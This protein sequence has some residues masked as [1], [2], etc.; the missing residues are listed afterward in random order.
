LARPL[1][2]AFINREL[3]HIKNKKRDEAEHIRLI[4]N[5]CLLT[6]GSLVAPYA[7]IA[8]LY[9]RKKGVNALVEALCHGDKLHLRSGSSDIYNFI[10]SR[11]ELYSLHRNSYQMYFRDGVNFTLPYRYSSQLRT[12]G[13]IKEEITK[14][15]T[16]SGR[17]SNFISQEDAA[18]LSLNKQYIINELL[19]NDK[20][21]TYSVYR[22]SSI[23]PK[24]SEVKLFGEIST[25][26]FVSHY[27]NEHELIVPTGI[28]EDPLIETF[29]YYPI[30]DVRFNHILLK[31]LGIESII[32][33]TQF[34]QP[35]FNLINDPDFAHY[36]S[37]R[38]SFFNVLAS[39]AK[40]AIGRPSCFYSMASALSD[41]DF[42]SAIQ[43]PQSAGSLAERLN[44]SMK[45]TA[46]RN[47]EFAKAMQT[48]G[49]DQR[50]EPTIAVFTATDL[51]D[52]IFKASAP[53]H[54][55]K[56]VGPMVYAGFSAG[57]YKNGASLNLLH[58]RTSAGS[59]GSH[60]S[61][62]IAELV[63]DQINPDLA[64]AV[65][66]AFGANENKQSAGDV[67]V[68]EHIVSYEKS[69]VES[70]AFQH[71]GDKIPCEPQLVS[72]S[73]YYDLQRPGFKLHVGG[74]LSGDKLVND[75]E[76]KSMLL[77]IDPKAVGGE[78][79]GAGLAQAF[80]I[81]GVPLG[82]IK[83][84]ADWGMQK[85]DTAQRKAAQNAFRLFF[86]AIKSLA[87]AD[88]ISKRR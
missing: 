85:D 77:A 24:P 69:K 51:E 55:F 26:L 10:E 21:A 25:R 42:G 15:V 38:I 32:D 14:T 46:A 79:E 65:G 72:Y 1:F 84:I 63:G 28:Y 49:V 67:L 22:D 2:L 47:L 62:R 57:L 39:F 83:G 80:H 66:I 36:N 70:G 74:I 29:D 78:M 30:Y 35:L 8:E 12:T 31:A 16:G 54:G 44:A 7:Q 3:L 40:T 45:R 64:V 81:K 53:I 73:R 5:C 88:Q 37:M 60:G 4:K 87:N 61:A 11:K 34:H 71:R 27:V 19:G 20:A 56:P 76:F 18:R 48:T 58:I 41:V 9:W 82:M 50:K 13:F 6:F 86:D 33:D 17:L 59:S 68:G 52:E 23:T 75:E 43:G